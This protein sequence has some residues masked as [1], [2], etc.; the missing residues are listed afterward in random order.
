[1]IAK[2]RHIGEALGVTQAMVSML[3]SGKRS[4]SWPL[5]QKLAAIFPGKDIVTW[6]NA[7]PQEL[8]RAFEQY[9]ATKEVA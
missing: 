2:Q 6:K 7:S 5:A 1:M 3:L 4:I 9:A 8:R